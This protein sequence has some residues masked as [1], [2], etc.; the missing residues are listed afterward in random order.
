MKN[1][2][3]K[4]NYIQSH[5]VL[6]P[7]KKVMKEETF[8]IIY[9]VFTMSRICDRKVLLSSIQNCTQPFVGK[10]TFCSMLSALSS[11]DVVQETGIF[12]IVVPA[13]GFATPFGINVAPSVFVCSCG[14]SLAMS[15]ETVCAAEMAV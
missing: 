15:F 6:F 4:I 11:N 5:S 7:H 13:G 8:R 12:I 14:D 3:F 10:S 9:I 1:T 2:I